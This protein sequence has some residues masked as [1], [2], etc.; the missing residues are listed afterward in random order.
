MDALA[1]PPTIP[2][3]R[4]VLYESLHWRCLP[5][6]VG[7]LLMGVPLQSAYY[8]LELLVEGVFVSRRFDL[9]LTWSS[10]VCMSGGNLVT[11]QKIT[12]KVK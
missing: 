5:V 3:R 2:M 10:R 8:I 9:G 7:Y 12:L 6:P 1:A 11:K 4:Y